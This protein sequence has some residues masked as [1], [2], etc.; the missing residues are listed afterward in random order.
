[1][2]A[3]EGFDSWGYLRFLLPSW[4]L[5][6]IGTAAV[7]VAVARNGWAGR[8]I[9]ITTIVVMVWWEV[10]Y[11]NRHGVFDQRQ[12]TRHMLLIAP[13]VREHTA[14]NSVV[15]ALQHSGA[16]RYYTGR[17]TLRY[18]YLPAETL[19]RDLEWLRSRGVRVYALF[20]E[21]ELGEF[22]TKFAGQRSLAALDQPVIDYRPGGM[23]LFD[24]TPGSDA[25]RPADPG[26]RRA[27]RSLRL[28]LA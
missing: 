15:I 16:A 3:Y 7:V 25:G 2:R 1:M 22:K 26:A 5:L 4:P 10:A 23:F 11:A 6:M 21:R 24:L 8:L 13:I 19:D 20:D 18:D 17:V 12:A 28:R 27:A 14:D 9:A